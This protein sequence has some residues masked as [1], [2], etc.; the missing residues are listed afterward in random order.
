MNIQPTPGIA[1]LAGTARAQA[2]GTDAD[3]RSPSADAADNPRLTAVSGIEAGAKSEDRDADGRQLLEQREGHACPDDK[4]G[5]DKNP[6]DKSQDD[7][8][9][10]TASGLLSPAPDEAAPHI[11][12]E[13]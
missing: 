9:G 5:D 10:G 13:A 7:K 6:D 8:S 11:D 12:F 2:R 4:S 3:R 1:S